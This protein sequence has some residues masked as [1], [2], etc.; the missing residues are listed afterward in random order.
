MS[1]KKGSNK[2]DGKDDRD[3]V[4]FSSGLFTGLNGFLGAI[5][6]LAG[7][8]GRFTRHQEETNDSTREGT[9]D[10]KKRESGK[11]IGGILNGLSDIVE[12]LNKISE[13]GESL[14]D[15]GN[16]TT[17]SKTGGIRGVYGF[18]VKTGLGE[19]GDAIRVEPF[20]NMHKDKET[21]EVVVQE[22][23]EPLVDVFEDEYATT[24]VAEM[25]GV[26]LED[27]QIEVQ[28]DVLTIS[29]K[30]GEKKYC[31]E[32]L[33]NHI[34]SKEHLKVTCNNGIVTIRCEKVV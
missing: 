24:L 21:G 7:A 23:H 12:K 2:D 14:S 5:D 28:D 9:A 25:P 29:A 17:S 11:N 22:I 31:K 27:I 33:L 18:T 19:K 32:M 13:N 6:K 34:L 8:S 16:F 3:K 20:G 4:E 30:K 26:G 15:T 10:E 1:D